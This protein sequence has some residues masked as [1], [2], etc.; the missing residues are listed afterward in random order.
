MQQETRA[1]L[2]QVFADEVGS[3]EKDDATFCWRTDSHEWMSR[4]RVRLLRW[5]VNAQMLPC[6]VIVCA[7]SRFGAGCWVV[8][9]R[10]HA[11]W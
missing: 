4:Q 6:L 9:H 3:K 7:P 5:V 8:Q 11:V 1:W 10:V 2:K